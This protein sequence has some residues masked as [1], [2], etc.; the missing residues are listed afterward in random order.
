MAT[1]N[2]S[3]YE[4][5]DRFIFWEILDAPLLATNWS[6]KVVLPLLGSLLGMAPFVPVTLHGAM[7]AGDPNWLE[8]PKGLSSKLPF[9]TCALAVEYVAV[10]AIIIDVYLFIIFIK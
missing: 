10:R 4:P 6:P 5:A 1:E 9:N 8:D 7:S 2:T 3:E